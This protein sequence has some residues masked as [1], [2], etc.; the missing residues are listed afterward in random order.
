MVV[1]AV[2]SG[3]DRCTDLVDWVTICVEMFM[4]V[5]FSGLFVC[6]DCGDQLCL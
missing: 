1:V 6:V 4:W 2:V 5:G 3:E